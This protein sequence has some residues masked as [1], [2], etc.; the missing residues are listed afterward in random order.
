MAESRR[1]KYRQ[2]VTVSGFSRE[3]SER[4][5]AY[6][7]NGRLSRHANLEMVAKTVLGFALWIATY[8]WL[9]TGR[10]TALQ[11]VGVYF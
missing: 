5:D 3:L 2:K 7:Q 4:V 10:F 8:L 1:F 6:F 11:V 9:I